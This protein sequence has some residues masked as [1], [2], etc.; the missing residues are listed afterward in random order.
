MQI[1]TIA[2]ALG[3]NIDGAWGTP[4]ISLLRAIA[5]FKRAGF[6]V[7]QQ[8]TISVTPPHGNVR[9]PAYHN[10]AITIR[11]SMSSAGLLR[12]AKRFERAAGR[13]SGR[14][15]GPRPLDIDIICHGGRIYAE[16]AEHTRP[17][18]LVLPHP[19]LQRRDFVLSP[20]AEVA[21]AWR[22]PKTGQTARAMLLQLSQP[23]RRRP[24]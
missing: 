23:R 8:S 11:G 21:P 1:S 15:W 22:H 17:G 24:I 5:E 13:R 20:L 14:R 10:A 7:L 6:T 18:Q 9:Q 19:E 3:A 2:L 12:L 16:G 4:V